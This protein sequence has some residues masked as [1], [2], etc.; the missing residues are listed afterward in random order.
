MKF[1]CLL[2]ILIFI[3]VFESCLRV[4]VLG[5]FQVSDFTLFRSFS[6]TLYF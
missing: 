4:V 5:V 2:R 3:D 6:A 1:L